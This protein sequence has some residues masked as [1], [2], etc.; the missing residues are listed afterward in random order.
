MRTADASACLL[1]PKSAAAA[2]VPAAK[3]FLLLMVLP[4]LKVLVAYKY[5]KKFFACQGFFVFP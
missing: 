3:A 4:S 1:A 5:S 2:S